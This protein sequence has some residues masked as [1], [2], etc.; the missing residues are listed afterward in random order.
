MSK[1]ESMV[2]NLVGGVCAVLIGCNL[3]LGLLN[4]RLTRLVGITSGQFN[5]AQQLQQ[6]ARNLVIR[7]AQDSQRDP[8]LRELLARH[9]INFSPT[10]E[11]AAK[12]TP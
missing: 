9:Q 11:T 6:T 12:P 4:Q 5:Q 10:N 8:S 7:I 1:S 3:V 2:L